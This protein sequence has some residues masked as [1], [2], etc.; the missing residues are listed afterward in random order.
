M[1][2]E[3]KSK[4][5]LIS[6]LTQLREKI[7]EL[8]SAQDKY[9]NLF[10][11]LPVGIFQST[12]SGR[13][14][15]A[16][17]TFAKMV[18]YTSPEELVNSIEDISTLY[19]N[20]ADRENVKRIFAEEGQLKGHIIRHINADGQIRYMSIYGKAVY[21]DTGEIDYYDGFT[22]DITERKLAE[23]NLRE[24]EELLSAIFENSLN[25]IMVADDLGNYI[26]VNQAA[27]DMFGYP[28]GKLLTMN[29]GDL[30]S[31]SMP[32]AAKRY[33]E[34]LQ[35]GQEIGEFDFI[36]ADNQ[37]R[38]AQ[39]HAVR[40]RENFNLS[41]LSD[42]TEQM[43]FEQELKETNR[44][45]QHITNTVPNLVYVFDLIKGHNIY[46]N[47]ETE[48]LL[49]VTLSDLQTKRQ[50]YFL[51]HIHPDDLEK[52]DEFN[53]QWPE[54]GDEQIFQK[55]YRLKDA[56]GAYRWIHSFERVFQR[57]SGGNPTQIIGTAIDVTERKQTENALRES[58]TRF[59]AIFHASPIPIALTRQRDNQLININKAWLD[60]T[61]YRR[62]EVIGT[63][64]GDL[65]IGVNPQER[66]IAIN[67]LEKQEKIIG[68]EYQIRQKSGE[69]RDILFSAEL[70]DLEGESFI[71][72]MGIDITERKQAEEK[73]KASEKRF[74]ALFE[75]AGGYC[76]ILDPNTADGIPIIIDANKAAC[77]SHGYTYEEFIGRPVADID[78]AEGKQLV[79][80]NTQRIMTGEPFYH[81]NTHVRKDGTTFPV[82]IQ[83]N[84]IDIEGEPPLIFTTEYDI[85]ERKKVEETLAHST[86]ALEKAQQ[87]AHL[88]SW[89]WHI[90]TNKLQWSNEMYRVFGIDKETFSG[91]LS[92]VINSAIHPDDRAKVEETNL[93]VINNKRPSPL[94]Y[95]VVWPDGTIHVVWAE[96]GELIF[97]EEGNP[98]V[99][100][101]IAQD[102]TERKRDQEILRKSEERFK[103]IFLQSPIAIEIYDATGLLQEANPTCLDM[104]GVSDIEHVKGFNLFDDPNIP[105]TEIEKLKEGHQI[106]FTSEFDFEIVKKENLYPT[107]K[108][109]KMF[110]EVYVKALVDEDGSI[111]GYLVHVQDITERKQAEIALLENQKRYQKA[112]AMGHVGNWEYDPITTKFWGSDEAKRIYGFELD[113]ED[114]TTDI[115]ESCIPERE[116]VHQALIDLIEHDKKYDLEFD[117][118]T[119]DKG[120]RKTI[121]S[122]AEVERDA[123][124][125]PLKVTG[126]ISDI[127]QRKQAEKSLRESENQFRRA[128]TD[129]PVPIMLHD[130]EDNILQL[131][132]G[133]THYSGYT[134]EDIPTMEDWT[135]KAYG[136]AT[137]TEKKYIDELFK[138]NK[139]V[140][141]GEWTVTAKDGSK[142]IWEFKTT[143]IGETA[144]GK[145]LLH[146]LAVDITERK[147]LDTVQKKLTERIEAGLRAGNIAW[148]EMELPSGNVIFDNRKAEMLGYAPELFTTYEDFTNL[149]HPDDYEQAMQAMRDHLQ[150]TTDTYE[151]EYRLKTSA[152]NYLWFRDIGR[153]TEIDETAGITRIVGIVEDIHTR[154]QSQIELEESAALYKS[155]FSALSEG[156]IVQ[157]KTDKIIMSND[158][159]TQILG[160]TVEQLLGKDAYD[161][162]WKALDRDGRPLDPKM[163]PSIV[164]MRTG[165]PVHNFIMNIHTSKKNRAI[166]SINAQPIFNSKHEITGTVL[167][168]TDITRQ[169]EAESKQE[170]LTQQLKQQAYQLQIVMDSVPEGLFVVD[171]KGRLLLANPTATNDLSVLTDGVEI[172]DKVRQL[173]GHSLEMFLIRP[174]ADLW[175]QL[176]WRDR[177]FE[178]IAKP[179]IT[180]NTTEGWVIVIRDV[181]TEMDIQKRIHQQDRLALVGQMAAGIAHDFNNILAIITLYADLSINDPRLPN[182]MVRRFEIIKT[183][184]DRATNLIRQI[185]DFGRR[186]VMERLPMD[187]I[188]FLKELVKLFQRTLPEDIEIRMSYS[189]TNFMIQGDPT[190]LQQAF[191]NLIVNARDAMP[192]GGRLHIDVTRKKPTRID[193]ALLSVQ[194][195]QL[196][197]DQTSQEWVCL[198]IQDT[199]EGIPADVLPHVFEPFYT[200]KEP[201]KGTGLG[202][203]QVFGII[204]QHDGEIDVVSELGE[205]S[206]FIVYL[207]LLATNDP[208]DEMTKPENF[209]HG[210]GELI[211]IAEDDLNLQKVM[212]ESLNKLN[213]R[214]L[215]AR[216]GREALAVMKEQGHEIALI[217]TDLVMPEMGGKVFLQA[218]NEAGIFPK[219]IIISG[220]PM[221]DDM[222][223]IESLNVIAWL[224]KPISLEKLAQIV[225]S[226]LA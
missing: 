73:L 203:A 206:A 138:I 47:H 122:I 99:L 156:L 119:Y 17:P 117:I 174:P 153:I 39:Y 53:K 179:L 25:A 106:S 208:T 59:T 188:S 88:G 126:V 96:A 182:D 43:Q 132:K 77:E 211:L 86:A 105:V 35:K 143:P 93:A 151:A 85:T 81:E 120:L 136:S 36:R 19:A 44:F 103:A 152:G 226:A 213:Y 115:V 45:N 76:M 113:S 79:V 8:E 205:G 42:I 83:A 118:I 191:M 21:N 189:E 16:N 181:T 107:S 110:W 70:I 112:Q 18:G 137:G 74:R 92:D 28:I 75:Q 12:P 216:N 98:V 68:F 165:K 100:S 202:L 177:H 24:R 134:I 104:F 2:D 34:Y 199:G 169:K 164:T 201:G 48:R 80:E 171:A 190:R 159:A 209:P 66:G 89:E 114:F 212:V 147:Q 20:P 144:N 61:G 82:S 200:T 69:I 170:Q 207:P 184:T 219:V 95:R 176:N 168:F 101:G 162:R 55:E 186:S 10:E 64:S 198:T 49:G 163:H 15:L 178:L 131:S 52:I 1:N 196:E 32:D 27:A 62:E 158:S 108:S 9:R 50:A 193:T 11:N 124:G 175:H 225:E 57:D 22:M 67:T 6:E 56:T 130:N 192:N 37:P 58:E 210:H 128:V 220:H 13:Y 71:L 154:K 54:A 4:A 155:V 197:Q 222:E 127:T 111:A 149:L 29:V 195:T 172:G 72:S 194:A 218:M 161:P 180:T 160:L 40:V 97:D 91:D 41:I 51:D 60:L 146:S 167:T 166:I 7:T 135:K 141:S 33:Q 221:T 63:N 14:R 38:V 31:K 145:R 84:R 23:T 5:Q 204:K 94:E 215:I 109:G 173:G 102:I 116:R 217:L 142:R 157:D 3:N 26:S 150:G 223:T 185:L 183:Q 224:E 140:Y 129:S 90:K 65:N 123:Q 30:R 87:V 139:T 121:H 187:F 133:W 46:I 214:T 78:D 125:K 148:W